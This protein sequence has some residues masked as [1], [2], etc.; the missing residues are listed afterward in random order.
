MSLREQ[1]KEQG[2][3]AERQSVEKSR[4]LAAVSHDLR[5]PL[6]AMGLATES[7]H[8]RE[9][10]HNPTVLQMKSA[11]GSAN[12]LL[13]SIIAM[14]RLETGSLKPNLCDFSIQPL[15]DRVDLA[16][17]AQATVKGLRWV[18][19]PS[20]ACV[21]SDPLLLERMVS[22]LVSNAVRYT[23]SG[24]V[25]LAVSAGPF[26]CCRCGTPVRASTRFITK[27]SFPSTFVGRQ[28]PRATAAWGW[29]SSA[30]RTAPRCWTSV[31]RCDPC[32]AAALAFRCASRWPEQCP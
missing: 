20:I 11:L 1:V 21:H 15:L 8:A 18:V 22:N 26:C 3:E 12:G 2:E 19:T 13:D 14:A 4:F 9:P 28:K 23:Q 32:L 29:A 16:F 10:R 5:Q 25:C 27:P 24:G 7:L 6:F 31:C 17:E 30:S